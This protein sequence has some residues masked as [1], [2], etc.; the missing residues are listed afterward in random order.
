[1]IKDPTL[2]AAIRAQA[3]A[4]KIPAGSALKAAPLLAAMTAPESSW[5]VRQYRPRFEA[6]YYIGGRWYVKSP[7]VRDD[8]D[9]FERCAAMS[10]GATQIMFTVARELGFRG[11][12][13]DL[14]VPDAAIRW[15]IAYL[16]RRTFAS[17][18]AAPTPDLVAPAKTLAQVADSWNTG[19]HRDGILPRAEYL[20]AMSAAY[21]TAVG[22]LT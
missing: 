15:T 21:Q 10:W 17:W 7:A 11:R 12:P 5:G 19:S 18:A 2:L 22:F 16:T 1:M 6:A 4:L 3:G 14:S 20:E 13:W 9:A 8:V